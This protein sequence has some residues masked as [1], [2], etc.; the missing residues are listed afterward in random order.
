MHNCGN[1]CRRLYGIHSTIQFILNSPHI[2]IASYLYL[3]SQNSDNKPM[4]EA[5]VDIII[6]SVIVLLIGVIYVTIGG[7][8]AKHAPDSEPGESEHLRRKMT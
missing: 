6:F 7:F 4:A 3:I 8:E 2:L 1:K 5:L